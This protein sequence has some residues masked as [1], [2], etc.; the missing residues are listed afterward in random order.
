MV[1]LEDLTQSW[2]RVI[3]V[4]FSCSAELLL[5]SAAFYLPL[6]EISGTTGYLDSSPLRETYMSSSLERSKLQGIPL[7][8]SVLMG[9][10][11]GLG[12]PFIHFCGANMVKWAYTKVSSV[13]FGSEFIATKIADALFVQCITSLTSSVFTAAFFIWSL[14]EREE[15]F[16]GGFYCVLGIWPL[17]IAA[18]AL[19][20]Y[21][22]WAPADPV[23]AEETQNLW[24][25]HR[26]EEV[27]EDSPDDSEAKERKDS[28]DSDSNDNESIQSEEQPKRGWFW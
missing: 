25:G 5:M 2:I 12:V 18:T 16:S 10:M 26:E 15:S 27:A 19:K 1:G 20:C 11:A 23:E 6:W 3:I 24:G 8:L 21:L 14:K 13:E 17:A 22:P 9:L 28:N 7:L 4:L